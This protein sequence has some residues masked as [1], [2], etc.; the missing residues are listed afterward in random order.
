M[1]EKRIE[2]RRDVSPLE[3]YRAWNS[4]LLAGD[5][6]GAAR[7]IDSD[8]WKEKCLGLTGWLTDFQVAVGHYVKN[9]VKPWRDLEMYEE[10]V[11]EGRDA[12]TI[13]FRVEAT[14]VGE[15][16]GV[17]ATGRRISFQAIRIVKIREGRV[18]GQWAQLDLWGIY[19][20]LTDFPVVSQETGH[21][22]E[23]R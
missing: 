13:R 12:V 10:D 7:L 17:P 2:T 1:N 15:F 8:R 3:I 4:L 22:E 19:S 11:V 16:L 14:H 23:R 9:M 18:T 5:T 21:S 6:E 20:Q